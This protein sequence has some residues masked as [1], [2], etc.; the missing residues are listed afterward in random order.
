MISNRVWLAGAFGN[1][2]RVESA[3]RLGLLEVRAERVTAAGNTALR[4]AKLVL[5][6]GDGDTS[7]PVRHVGLAS[8]PAFQDTFVDC[9]AF[10]AS[11]SQH[12]RSEVP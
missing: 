1:Y 6:S 4:G 7:V 11:I 2:T 5:L 9:L 3:V 8:D 10:E 12:S